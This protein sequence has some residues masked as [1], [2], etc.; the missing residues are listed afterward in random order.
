VG[1]HRRASRRGHTAHPYAPLGFPFQA[2]RTSSTRPAVGMP[3]SGRRLFP[4]RKGQQKERWGPRENKTKQQQVGSATRKTW[5]LAGATGGRLR[6]GK[7]AARGNLTVR[8]CCRRPARRSMRIAGAKE[9]ATETNLSG[10]RCSSGHDWRPFG[11]VIGRRAFLGS[12]RRLEVI[13]T[14]PDLIRSL[15]RLQM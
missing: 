6:W 10:H 14:I 12:G 11:N 7:G 9:S 5:R 4:T 13:L 15:L 1:I 8:R 2:T 3:E